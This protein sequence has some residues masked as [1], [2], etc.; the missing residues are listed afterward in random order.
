MRCI[1]LLVLLCPGLGRAEEDARENVG[2]AEQ[3][4]RLAS[5]WAERRDPAKAEEALR[6]ATAAL[7]ERPDA[8]DRMF[9]KARLLL[10]VG[11]SATDP[12]ER[13]R[14]G[15]AAGMSG[16]GSHAPSPSGS[17][18]ITSLPWASAAATAAGP[19]S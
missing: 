13:K 7:A 8:P 12:K 5:L 3:V 9:W 4:A 16:T 19:E 2:G 18:D 14:F 10:W 17:P 11:D 15:S 6:L 1:A